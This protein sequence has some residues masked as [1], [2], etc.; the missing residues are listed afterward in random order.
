MVYDFLLAERGYPERIGS[1]SSKRL[2]ASRLGLKSFRRAPAPPGAG[3]RRPGASGGR[4]RGLRI[5]RASGRRAARGRRAALRPRQHPHV[6]V[7]HLVAVVLQAQRPR[8]DLARVAAGGRSGELDVVVDADAVMPHGHARAGGLRAARV[9]ARAGELDVVALPALGW[10][11]GVHGRDVLAVDRAAVAHPG[12]EAVGVEH[13]D[14]VASLHVDA[15]VAAL[16]A[17]GLG[18]GGRE[19]FDVIEPVAEALLRDQVAGAGDDLEGLADRPPGGGLRLGMLP[20]LEVARRLRPPVEPDQDLGR[21]RGARGVVR[22]A[23]RPVE[24]AQEDLLEVLVAP[25]L[26]AV[27]EGAV[28]DAAFG[29]L[30]RPGQRVVAVGALAERHV[31]RGRIE[32]QRDAQRV[33]AVVAELVDLVG[34][35]EG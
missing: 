19:E 24:T 3:P 7:A 17:A 33:A 21:L 23:D 11:A 9:E 18:H 2:L 30:A 34:E 25:D 31:D 16:L 10:A 5:L 32:R 22:T 29:P 6:A 26:L 1:R 15:A 28:E 12:L 35:N 13:L 4:P 14:L 8:R 20:V 27:S